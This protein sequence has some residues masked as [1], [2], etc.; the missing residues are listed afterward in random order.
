MYIPSRLFFTSLFEMPMIQ[1]SIIF[2]TPSFLLS[3]PRCDATTLT[4]NVL[5]KQLQPMTFR[6]CTKKS[7]SRRPESCR[8]ITEPTNP[9][10]SRISLSPFAMSAARMR[11]FVGYLLSSVYRSRDRK[12]RRG[13]APRVSM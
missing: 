3:M 5:R 1:I 10:S 12:T 6:P 2:S 9:K 7:Q 11:F 13:M 4:L 8:V